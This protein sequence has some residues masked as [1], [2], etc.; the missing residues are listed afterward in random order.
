MT[1]DRTQRR[2]RVTSILAHSTPGDPQTPEAILPFVYDELRRLA[3]RHMNREAGGHTFQPTAL[4][5]EAYLRLVGDAEARWDGRG[6]F[7]AAAARAMRRI[8]VD[9]ARRKAALRHGGGRRRVD[10]DKLDVTLAEAS[11]HPEDLLALDEALSRLETIDPRKAS[12]VML[13]HFAGLTIEETARALDL[14]IT[15]VKDEWAFAR[16]WLHGELGP[17]DRTG[18]DA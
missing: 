9:H 4:V 14:S 16:A 7:Y 17:S 10:L 1:E 5:H 12:I 2:E 8:L 11:G 6:H 15:T 18:R 3:E 13:R